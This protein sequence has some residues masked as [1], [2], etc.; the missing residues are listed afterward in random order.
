MGR[1]LQEQLDAK[2][3]ECLLLSCFEVIVSWLSQVEKVSVV[4]PVSKKHKN[5]LFKG[6]YTRLPGNR[7]PQAE[8]SP[9]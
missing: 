1:T 9:L 3:D 6:R 7:L 2:G 4:T 5:Y 8:S